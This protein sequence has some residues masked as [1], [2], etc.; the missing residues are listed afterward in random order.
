MHCN[1]EVIASSSIGSVVCCECGNVA[2]NIGDKSI[3]VPKG[4]FTKFSAMID[5]AYAN[6]VS[7]ELSKYGH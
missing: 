4:S 2:V 6:L 1:S 5:V 7:N 3:L